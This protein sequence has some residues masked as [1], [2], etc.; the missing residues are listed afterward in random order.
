LIITCRA[1]RE[2]QM[3]R[4]TREH[5]FHIRPVGS[6]VEETHESGH[7]LKRAVGPWSLM[8]L[9]VGAIVGTG[10]FVV[11]GE[12]LA[13]AGPAVI[14][15]FMVAAVV[16]LFSALSYA[17]LAS[18][19][20][21]AGSAYTYAY[22]TLGEIVAWVIGW[23]LILEYGVS[24]AAIA[25]GWGANLNAFLDTTFGVALPES[26]TTSLPDGGINLPAVFIV[27]AITFL[28]IRGV[29]ETAALNN[30]MVVIKLAVL[31]LFIVLAFTAFNADN[32]QPF[33]PEGWGGGVFGGNTG[34]L[35]AAA[36]IFFAYIGFDAVAT[37]SEEANNPKRDLPFAIIGS[38][39]ICTIIY[40][41]VS[42]GAV[43]ALP[44]EQLAAT[45]APLSEALEEGV[46]LGWA[47]SLT[48]FGALVAIT[49]VLLVILYGQTRI[50]FAMARDG[51]VPESWA[52]V[53]PRT[54][55]PVKLTIG[56]GIFAAVVAALVP[57]GAIVEMVNIGTL[58]AFILVNAGVMILRR[59]RPDMPRP[60]KVPVPYIWCPIGIILCVYLMLGLPVAT[61]IRFVGWLAIG[62]AIY[63]LYGYSH[64]RLRHHYP[65]VPDL[66]EIEPDAP[67]TPTTG[68]R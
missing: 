22:A 21:V 42:I 35:A 23:D 36:I 11:V 65:D 52:D 38:L 53:N 8:A 20:P 49:S 10:I 34:V 7:E 19:I 60:F 46:G 55:T 48:A 5:L 25:V 61:Y 14:I 54:G 6:L 47:A 26:L 24:V 30:I 63:L 44:A 2:A 31:G 67:E 4:F 28:L 15:S 39:V 12:G 33:A 58:F 13:R 43:G 41:L 64:S 68:A 3:P 1:V 32:L 45:D 16:C 18:S 56:F 51:L 59:T 66:P 57:L 27:L 9:G 40:I 62:V 17:E 37:G 50:F 29:K